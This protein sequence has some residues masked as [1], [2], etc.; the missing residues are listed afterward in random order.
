MPSFNL[1]P[2]FYQTRLHDCAIACLRMIAQY[3]GKE[4]TNEQYSLD[5]NGISVL[6]ITLIANKIGLDSISFRVNMRDLE[7]VI[8]LPIIVFW[9]AKHFIVVYEIDN[10]YVTVC[11][12]AIGRISYTYEEFKNGW[13]GDDEKGVLIVF[14][15]I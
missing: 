15:S 7:T 5:D 9:E 8:P 2:I 12:P 11:D 14:E 10:E 3:F 1:F 13:Y 4:I 6:D